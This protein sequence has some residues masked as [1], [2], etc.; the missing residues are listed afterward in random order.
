MADPGDPQTSEQHDPGLA[1]P[2]QEPDPVCNPNKPP[3]EQMQQESG[4]PG[5]SNQQ[6]ES[7]KGKKSFPLSDAELLPFALAETNHNE[8][9]QMKILDLTGTRA[10]GFTSRSSLASRHR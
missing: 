10:L 3:Q 8:L 7:G 1:P 6:R 5:Q 9:N 2:I 4:L